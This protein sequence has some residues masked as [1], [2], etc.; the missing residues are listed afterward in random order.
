MKIGKSIFAAADTI[1][2]IIHNSASRN[3]SRAKVKQSFYFKQT[4]R[5]VPLEI[6]EIV[7]HYNK[8]A[9]QHLGDNLQ[10]RW[11]GPYVILGKHQKNKYQVKDMKGY[12][13]KTYLNGSNLKQYL[14]K[15]EVNENDPDL[16]PVSELPDTP[17]TVDDLLASIN[18]KKNRLQS[19]G[20]KKRKT[21]D[22]ELLFPDLQGHKKK[23]K[24]NP[25]PH[26]HLL[27]QSETKGNIL[28]LQ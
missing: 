19:K 8:R 16:I 28:S 5:G 7:L 4:H 12:V 11:L 18:Y 27:N 26:L 9:G 24:T 15:N 25:R 20:G 14:T 1:R 3:I 13:L 23:K 10:G 21:S 6:G 22:A 2:Q 17:D